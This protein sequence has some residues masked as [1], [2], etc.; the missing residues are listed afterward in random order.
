MTK[1]HMKDILLANGFK[2]KE[3]AGG[4]QDLNPYVYDAVSKVVLLTLGQIVA[5]MT[6]FIDSKDMAE[7]Q[8]MLYKCIAVIDKHIA[9]LRE[10]TDD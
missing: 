5:D 9:E 7:S 8:H 6:D 10:V 4:T 3:Q 1:D 2:L